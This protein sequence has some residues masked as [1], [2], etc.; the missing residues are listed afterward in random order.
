MKI[1]EPYKAIFLHHLE[2]ELVPKE[3]TNLYKPISY[4]LSIGGKRLRPLL[5][6]LMCDVYGS[7]PEKAIHAAMAVE[8]FHNFT[9]VHDDV[10]D[11]AALRRGKQTVH[12]KWNLNTAI[13]SGDAMM[14]RAYQFLENY[15]NDLHKPLTKLFSNTAL[16]VC[17]G[18]QLDVDFEEREDVTIEEYLQMIIYKT[19]VLIGAAMKMG[20]LIANVPDNEA[21]KVY[22]FGLNLG[23]AFQLK[24]D[25]LD[26]FGNAE[27]FGKKI[28]G[29]ILE[30]KKTLL[31][32]KA[33]EK[34]DE[35]SKK[36]LTAWYRT[37]EQSEQK[38]KEVTN[39]FSSLKIDEVVK[40]EI[41]KYNEK[42]FEFLSQLSISKEKSTILKQF[43]DQLSKRII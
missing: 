30:N 16:Q 25:Y 23:I 9:L 5:A 14:I 22:D 4:I 39:I 29:D 41:V 40:K 17:E 18:Q 43:S 38:I 12:E 6:M 24:D 26:T 32:L 10:M 1:L 3:P 21:Q 20:A 15:D 28:G 19:S 36:K 11:H 7:A 34:A 2:E 37:N 13:L 27:I 8:I 42:A 31:Y 33:L 35:T